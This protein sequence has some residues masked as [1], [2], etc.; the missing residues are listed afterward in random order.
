MDSLEHTIETVRDFCE[1]RDWDQFHSP[2]ELGIGI[3]NEANELL[4]IFRFKTDE[5]MK[6]IMRDE[7][8]RKDISQELADVMFFLVRFSQM[9]DFD[10]I[11]SIKEKVKINNQ[12]YPV[13]KSKGRNVKYDEFD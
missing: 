5:E 2:K 8:K 7:L 12:K 4:S 11:Q 6:D 10:L 9:Y 1:A 3:S 13:E